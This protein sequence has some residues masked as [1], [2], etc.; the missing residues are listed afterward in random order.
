MSMGTWQAVFD[1]LEL[2]G[3]PDKYKVLQLREVR[4]VL[5]ISRSKPPKF[6]GDAAL[7]D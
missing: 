4:A 1:A 6:L 5:S 7:R 3:W 2:S